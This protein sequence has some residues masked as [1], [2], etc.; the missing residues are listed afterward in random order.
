M[1]LLNGSII[2]LH[3]LAVQT[4]VHIS[5]HGE[6]EIGIIGAWPGLDC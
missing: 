3:N 1:V 4:G 2:I 5:E 6:E